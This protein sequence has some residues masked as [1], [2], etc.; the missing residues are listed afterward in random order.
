MRPVEVLLVEDNAG[1]AL[2]TRQSLNECHSP[3]RLHI[4]RDGEQALQIL[5]DRQFNPDVIILD[6]NIPRI[7]G[8][9]LLERFREREIPI[10]I[11]SS[12]WNQLEI[13]RALQ[14]GAREFIKKPM[15]IQ[16]FTNAVCGIVDRWA[17]SD[18]GCT[19][20]KS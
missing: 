2:L 14:L 11:F 12:S 16:E 7:S 6:L 18:S 19:C 9:S 5:G 4:A 17:L 1:D 15:D 8:L 20:G 3:V 13:D 10:V